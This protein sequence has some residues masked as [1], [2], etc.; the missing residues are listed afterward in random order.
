KYFKSPESEDEDNNNDTTDIKYVQKR[1]RKQASKLPSLPSNFEPLVHQSPLHYASVRLPPHI[2]VVK[3]ARTIGR[4]WKNL[5]C[6]EFFVWVALVVYQ[7]LFKLLSLGQYWNKDPKLPVHHISKQISLKHFELI[8]RFLHI[9]PL[10]HALTLKHYFEKLE[11]LL[12]SIHDASKQYY[13]LS[14]TI[15]VDKIMIRFSR[16]SV[17]TVQIKSKPISKGF[18]IFSLCEA[19]YTYTFLPSLRVL[20]NNVTNMDGLNQT[21][22]LVLHL[23]RQL[24]YLQFPYDIY[25]DN[26]FTFRFPKKLKIDKDIKFDWDIRSGIE[27]D[28][29]R[30]RPRETST[31]MMKVHAVFRS[32][33]KKN[34]KIPKV[35]D[36]YNHH[37]NDIANINAYLI[38]RN[39]ESM[40]G[41]KQFHNNLVWGL[42]DFANNGS[43]VQLRDY[44]K[45]KKLQS[46]SKE[47]KKPSKVTKH[48]KLS[49][50]RLALRNHLAV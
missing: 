13:I 12:S 34:L 15:S 39:L 41:H 23:V 33:P 2:N 11:L 32:D 36:D 5:T 37:M 4:C 46:N 30:R 9:S 20:P 16:R 6:K 35:I 7:R 47:K 49:D 25:M 22:S 42:I 28:S 27:V 48:F 43:K 18:K 44:S 31:N 40:Q 10:A 29:E 1:K 17:H 24:P 26:Y 19:G 21:R 8:K 45:E 50:H 38:T 14:S 3:G